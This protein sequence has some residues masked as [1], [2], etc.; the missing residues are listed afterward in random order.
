MTPDEQERDT[1]AYDHAVEM[2][3]AG[4]YDSMTYGGMDFTD[5]DYNDRTHLT[6][7]GGNKLAHAVSAKVRDMSAKL[8]Y[9]SP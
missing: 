8:G 7:L 1:L 6:A 3:K 4:G 5:F 9:L 2:W